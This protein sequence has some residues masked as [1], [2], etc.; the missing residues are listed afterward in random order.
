MH[1]NDVRCSY[2][3]SC[4]CTLRAQSD[5]ASAQGKFAKAT[6]TACFHRQF[7][8]EWSF[9]GHVTHL[10]CLRIAAFRLSGTRPTCSTHTEPVAADDERKEQEA[11]SSE[12]IHQVQQ[13]AG[14]VTLESQ[15][16]P[17]EQAHL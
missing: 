13:C 10:V 3:S 1:M 17:G 8:Q 12:S 2:F 16:A 9:H 11:H 14:D 4:M 7:A 5:I 15:C 6:A